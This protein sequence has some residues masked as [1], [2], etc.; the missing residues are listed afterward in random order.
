M[1]FNQLFYL[2]K[3][4]ERDYRDNYNRGHD[5]RYAFDDRNDRYR[6]RDGYGSYRGD[7]QFYRPSSFNRNV[8]YKKK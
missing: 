6:P 2:F 1:K 7:E 4:N 3:G 5:Q 8:N